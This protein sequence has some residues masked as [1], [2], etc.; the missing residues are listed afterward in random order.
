MRIVAG[1]YRGRRLV[2][3]QGRETRP[4]ADRVREAVFAMLGDITGCQVLDLFAGSGAMA[5]EAISR[6]AA[7]G[8]CID[9]ATQAIS[10]IRAN[11]QMLDD[12]DVLRVVRRDWRDALRAEARAHRRYGLCVLDPPYSLL[13]RIMDDLSRALIPVLGAG[14]VIV[15]EGAAADGPV[16]LPGLAVAS[17]TDRT[18]GSTTISIIR[19]ETPTT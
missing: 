19:T 13:P 16:T 1:V 18:Y 5:L 6:G 3:P 17:R 10:A 4:T 14:A 12:P 11:A 8:V 7:G 9:S 2:A 15:V